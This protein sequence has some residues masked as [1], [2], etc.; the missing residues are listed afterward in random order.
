[1]RFKFTY[2][3]PAKLPR[4]AG[5]DITDPVANARQT[6][7]ADPR[8]IA[9]RL[10]GMRELEKPPQPTMLAEASSQQKLAAAAGIAATSGLRPH[11]STAG[12]PLP[13]PTNGLRT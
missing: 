13:R 9:T 3:E 6:G 1:M 10:R 11:T 4:A 5:T 12:T 7:E 2:Q 8:L